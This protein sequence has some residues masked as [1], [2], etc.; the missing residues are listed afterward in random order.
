MT[1]KKAM[2]DSIKLLLI[3]VTVIRVSIHKSQSGEGICSA[4][5]YFATKD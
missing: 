3:K 5:D 4:N 1:E 2:F